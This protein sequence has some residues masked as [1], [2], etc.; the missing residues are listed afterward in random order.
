MKNILP[1]SKPWQRERAKKIHR[2]CLCVQSAETR[3]EKIFRAIQ[4]TARRYNGRKLKS[5]PSRRL[6]LCPGTLRRWWDIWKR[7][8]QMPAAL[9]LKFRAR[10]PYVPRPLLIRFVEFCAT[11]RL[12]SV[13]AAWQKFSKLNRNKAALEIT[14]SQVAWHFRAT[15]FYLMQRQLKTIAA[16]QAALD[17]TKF[18]AM[19][20]I[21]NRLPER[22][23]RRR[24]KRGTDFQV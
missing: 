12:P 7:N 23:P 6:R 24:V 18:A 3:G 4:R 11:N 14:Y 16:T 19:A 13:K 20:D 15:S 2:A 9:Y 1:E 5:D 22:P 21:T 10:P 17:E 8:G